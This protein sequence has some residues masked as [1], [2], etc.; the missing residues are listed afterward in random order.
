MGKLFN[1]CSFSMS[2]YKKVWRWIVVLSAQHCEW[3]ILDLQCCISF[4]C[5]AKWL[6]DVYKNL[7]F[8]QILFSYRLLQ[9]IEFPELYSRSFLIVCFICMYTL[10]Q[11]PNLSLPTPFP[12]GNHKFVSY[13]CGSSSVLYI[14][15]PVSFLLEIF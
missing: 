8:F 6:S 1:G 10:I 7:I 4:R 5:T 2:W 9:N 11:D 3:I 15:A 14:S 13:V 12:F